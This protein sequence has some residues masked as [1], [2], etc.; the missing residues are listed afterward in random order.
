MSQTATKMALDAATENGKPQ[1][2]HEQIA[3]LAYLLWHERGCPDGSP[4]TDW[5]QAEQA[6]ANSQ[7]EEERID[8]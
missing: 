3:V 5:F 8:F 6:L 4:E 7:Y 2:H 1:T